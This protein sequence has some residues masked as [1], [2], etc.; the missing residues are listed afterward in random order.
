MDLFQKIANLPLP[1]GT[2]LLEV[3]KTEYV[4]NHEVNLIKIIAF[5]FDII[6]SATR[7]G[8]KQAAR[9]RVQN[10]SNIAVGWKIFEKSGQT[11]NFIWSHIGSKVVGNDS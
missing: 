10:F 7:I 11:L 2:S 1:V 6:N 3:T 4:F 5:W 9:T 8:I